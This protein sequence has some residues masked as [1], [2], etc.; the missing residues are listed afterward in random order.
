MMARKE[1]VVRADTRQRR[2]AAQEGGRQGGAR[3]GRLA[4]GLRVVVEPG[5]PRGRRS[6]GRGGGPADRLAPAGE[7]LTVEADKIIIATGSE[8]AQLPMFDFAQPAVLTSTSALELT[9][10]PQSLLIVGAG[11]IGCEFASFFAELGTQITMVEMM[12]QM[13]PQEDNRL[14]K[15]FQGVYRKRGIQVLL[16]HQGGEHHRVRR[17]PR[18]GEAVRRV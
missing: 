3:H 6:P 5:A 14:A 9:E 16:K 10:I 1:R 15:Q 12:P 7:A 11:A 18:G 17:R 2:D 13:L 8:P 4:P